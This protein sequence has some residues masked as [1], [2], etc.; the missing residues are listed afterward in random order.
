MALDLL[1]RGVVKTEE[2]NTHVFTLDQVVEALE[3][4]KQ[5]T[6]LKVLVV[7]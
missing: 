5:G 7:N 4:M 3:T 2:L 6:G 1:A